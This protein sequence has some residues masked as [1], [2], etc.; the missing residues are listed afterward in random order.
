MQAGVMAETRETAGVTMRLIVEF[1]RVR[2]G[3]D[4]LREVLARAGETRPVE[5][6]EDEG[7]WSSYDQKIAL[8]AAAA[9]VTGR[10][11]IARAIGETVLRASV[12]TTLRMA[13]VLLGSPATLLKAIPRANAKF[14]TAGNMRSE[15]VTATSATL[16]YRVR[17]GFELSHFDCDYTMGLLSQVPVLFDLPAA[18]VEHPECQVKGATECVY[19]VRWYRRSRWTRFRRRHSVATDTL[20]SRLSQL[21]AT[22]NDLVAT[23]D[24]DVVLDAIASRAVTAVNAERFLL[25]VRLRDGEEP[26]VRSD[27]LDPVESRR[28]A[29]RLLDGGDV[30]LDGYHTLKAD[31]RTSTRSY[32]HLAAFA[33]EEFLD[34]EVDLLESYAGLAA[35]AL[36]AVT[37]LAE[38]D[39]RR[40]TAETLLALASQ[41][42]GADTAEE[43]AGAVAAAAN[44]VVDA[45]VAS[46]LFFAEGSDS[47]VVAGYAGWPDDL[48][49]MLPHVRVRPQ[50]TPEIDQLLT[51]PEA[52][53]LFDDDCEDPFLRMLLRSF[54]TKRIAVVTL[55]G[56]SRVHGVLL[57]GW[58]TGSSAP[59]VGDSLFTK[60]NALADQAT[61]ALDKAELLRRVQWQ[62]TS[63][64]LTGI[65]NRRVLSDRL[66]EIV[67]RGDPATSSALLFIDLDGFKSVNDTLGHA[68]GDELLKTVAGRLRRSVRTDDLVARLGGDEFTVLLDSVLG[69][70]EALKIAEVIR[71]E[72][73]MP[74]VIEDHVVDVDCSVGVILIRPGVHTAT[75]VLRAA[76]AAMY[77][78]KKSGGGRCVLFEV[79]GLAPDRPTSGTPS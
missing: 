13:L 8:F 26:K 45:D 73:A 20:L 35:T 58:L 65:A 64:A 66:E 32:G 11:D 43:I 41:L 4:A 61:N 56:T 22:L 5:V 71:S 29:D 37:A 10:A 38:A 62:A 19:K 76:D 14:S 46:T 72:V 48:V 28:M 54:R 49:E 70:E 33:T 25:A 79:A 77:G 60:L 75:E 57:A 15:D 63:D 23:D 17:E 47:L 74:F 39:E 3:D 27:G 16:Y 78:A 53:R 30:Q 40:R 50:D 34:T 44:T 9:E 51:R 59:E 18:V 1:I 24:V 52:A 21:Q 6:L 68:A 55:R 12:A 67:A 2:F 42:H 36:E 31:V 7:V 69:E